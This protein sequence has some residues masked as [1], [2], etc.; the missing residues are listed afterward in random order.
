MALS[1]LF[2]AVA[3]RTTKQEVE[4]DPEVMD[5]DAFALLLQRII[6]NDPELEARAHATVT[7]I[8]IE[9]ECLLCP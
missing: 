4:D 5:P 3:P 9:I 1:F 7:A 8:D 6:D 2:F